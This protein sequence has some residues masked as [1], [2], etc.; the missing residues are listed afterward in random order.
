MTEINPL[1]ALEALHRELVAVLE[2]RFESLHVLELQLD[3]HAQA[4]KKLL[5]KPA[6]NEGSRNAI[7]TG[8]SILRRFAQ[9]GMLT[10]SHK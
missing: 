2:H 4:F 10:A 3:A 7:K 1:D 5:D 6:K 9:Y 8:P